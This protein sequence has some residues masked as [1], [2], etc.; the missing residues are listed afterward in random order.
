M[1]QAQANSIGTWAKVV[2]IYLYFLEAL[3]HSVSEDEAWSG[4]TAEK[5]FGILQKEEFA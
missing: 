4:E 5:A 1:E 3:S 2:S